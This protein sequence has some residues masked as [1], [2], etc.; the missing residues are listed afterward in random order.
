MAQQQ[1]SKGAISTSKAEPARGGGGECSC[2]RLL[3]YRLL[4]VL[5]VITGG[6][7]GFLSHTTPEAYHVGKTLS[8]V[9][10]HHRDPSGTLP[11]D[12][13]KETQT[14]EQLT[15]GKAYMIGLRTSG[16]L[17]LIVGIAHLSFPPT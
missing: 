13:G 6:T 4:V 2:P 11:G 14:P 15:S 7:F 12:T 8:K 16:G 1:I 10:G 5:T 9:S 17:I 3:E